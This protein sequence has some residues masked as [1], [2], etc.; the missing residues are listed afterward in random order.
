MCVRVYLI[1]L[2]ILFV[3]D[4]I[5]IRGYEYEYM[6]F[7]IVRLLVFFYWLFILCFSKGVRLMS[8]VCVLGNSFRW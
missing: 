3:K 7:L 1:K 6:L 4:S 2:V 8:S 5:E